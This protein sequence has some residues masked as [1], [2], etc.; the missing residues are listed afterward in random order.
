MAVANVRISVRV[1]HVR[2]E[3]PRPLEV[4]ASD[5]EVEARADERFRFAPVQLVE[6]EAVGFVCGQVAGPPFPFR[7][8]G[9]VTGDKQRNS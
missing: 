2:R 8:V 5:Q 1:M 6:V 4:A 7:L 9:S 3:S